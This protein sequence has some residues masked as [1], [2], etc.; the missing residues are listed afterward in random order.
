MVVARKNVRDFRGSVINP[1][2]HLVLPDKRRLRHNDVSEL[3]SNQQFWVDN[4]HMRSLIPQLL[5]Y[6]VSPY[7]GKPAVAGKKVRGGAPGLEASAGNPALASRLAD[8]YARRTPTHLP[9]QRDPT[10]NTPPWLRNQVVHER[11]ANNTNMP[12]DPAPAPTP[13]NFAPLVDE[14]K[15][16]SDSDP[17]YPKGIRPPPAFN[18]AT[19]PGKPGTSVPANF[20]P[21]PGKSGPPAPFNFKP[22]PGNARKNAPP[23]ASG[24]I[25]DDA[26]DEWLNSS[27][28]AATPRKPRKNET[29]PEL[30]FARFCSLCCGRPCEAA[31][32]EERRRS[33][34]RLVLW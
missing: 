9:P 15:R 5:E 10:A 2:D 13:F 7:K 26:D 19:L 17:P 1:R 11:N 14:R 33:S 31:R 20:R 27:K 34:D 12:N 22:L 16:K 21:L 25:D 8:H 32:P 6:M 23:A 30:R 29:K 3:L 18:F 28:P 4:P 24:P